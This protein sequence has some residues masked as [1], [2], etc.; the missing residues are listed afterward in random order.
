MAK[1]RKK[2]GSKRKSPR[3]NPSNPR[4]AKKGS[5]RRR[6]RNP[7]T[8]AERAG[9]LAAGAVIA[10][11]T[12]VGTTY[13]QSK[14]MPG[15]TTSLYG[16]P[17][18]VFLAGVGIARTMPML[19]VSMALG[20]FAPFSVALTSKLLTATTPA[21]P[22]TPS[23]PAATA[24]GISRAYRAMRA[25]DMGRGRGMRAVDLGAVDMGRYGYAYSN[26]R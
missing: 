15:Q 21:T 8:F 6:R 17:A 2:S 4:R 12:A 18:L 24:A 5:H 11:G 19:G 10:L 23:T 20:A 3:R 16:I 25:I 22:T 1:K 13:A 14:I 26:Q 9:Q 7:G